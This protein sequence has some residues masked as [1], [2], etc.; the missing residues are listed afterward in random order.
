[1][2]AFARRYGEAGIERAGGEFA[3]RD[4]VAARI[5]AGEEVPGVVEALAR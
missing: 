2:R 3:L 5:D 1:V 4:A